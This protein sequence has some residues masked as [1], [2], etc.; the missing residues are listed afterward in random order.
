ML[1][2]LF[3]RFA[4]PPRFPI[5]RAYGALAARDDHSFKRLGEP[6]QVIGEENQ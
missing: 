1:S 3:F 5:P 6:Q 2:A 4:R